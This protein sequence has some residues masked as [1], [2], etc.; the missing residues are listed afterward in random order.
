MIIYKVAYTRGSD[1]L[2]FYAKNKK[3]AMKMRSM[4]KKQERIDLKQY[5]NDG[6]A[7]VGN[8]EKTV[9][10]YTK[11]AIIHFLNQK[12]IYMNN[13]DLAQMVFTIENQLDE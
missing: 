10:G 9:I 11:D 1:H 5:G 7:N 8:P 2:C 13:M 12:A 6:V 3:E 4:L